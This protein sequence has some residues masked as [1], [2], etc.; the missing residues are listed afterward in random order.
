MYEHINAP[1]KITNALAVVLKSKVSLQI[2]CIV[3]YTI[4]NHELL[5]NQ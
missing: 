4:N 2:G 3:K 5:R 1:S